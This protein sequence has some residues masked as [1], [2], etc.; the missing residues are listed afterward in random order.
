MDGAPPRISVD[1]IRVSDAEPDGSLK[2]GRVLLE[3]EGPDGMKV[4]SQ[5]NLFIASRNGIEIFNAEG[6]RQE[7]IAVPE[8]PANCAFGGPDNTTLFITART[9]L[10]LAGLTVPG[11]KVWK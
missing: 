2:N 3:V 4:D 6:V 5:G 10:Y 9:G 7:I 1:E 11:V 8:V